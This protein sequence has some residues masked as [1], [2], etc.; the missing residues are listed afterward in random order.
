MDNYLDNLGTIDTANKPQRQRSDSE[1]VEA[2]EEWSYPSHTNRDSDNQAQEDVVD[3]QLNRIFNE[4]STAND[5]WTD[6]QIT[7]LFGRPEQQKENLP[8][9][10]LDNR[11]KAG[12]ALMLAENQED[13]RP[14]VSPVV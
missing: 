4:P 10:T 3:Q 2:F 8:V 9:K 11:L 12:I 13:I 5:P 14:T 6:Q 1:K 7:Q